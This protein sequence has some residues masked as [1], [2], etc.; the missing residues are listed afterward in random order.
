MFEVAP[1]LPWCEL[2][3]QQLEQLV[4]QHTCLQQAMLVLGQYVVEFEQLHPLPVRQYVPDELS[5]LLGVVTAEH[6]QR[7]PGRPPDVRPSGGDRAGGYSSVVDQA[8]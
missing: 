7:V 5:L 1:P 6:E 3:A 2:R 4:A 8:R